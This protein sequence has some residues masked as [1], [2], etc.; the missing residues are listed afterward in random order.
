V[1][2]V[3]TLAGTLDVQVEAGEAVSVGIVAGS[4]RAKV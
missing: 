3:R 1:K 4:P 2:G